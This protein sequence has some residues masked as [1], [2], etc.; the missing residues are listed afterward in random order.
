MMRDRIESI[1][2]FIL[3]III[4]MILAW[5]GGWFIAASLGLANL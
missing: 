2:T 1:A 5:L 3:G 4:L